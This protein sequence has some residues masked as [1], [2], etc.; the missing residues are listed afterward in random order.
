MNEYANDMVGKG[1]ERSRFRDNDPHSIGIELK[2]NLMTEIQLTD[3][4]LE[5]QYLN[6][7]LIPVK[8]PCT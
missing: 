1:V 4:Q 2:M 6:V 8:E 7:C 5:N 3:F